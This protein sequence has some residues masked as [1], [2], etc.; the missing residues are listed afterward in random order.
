MKKNIIDLETCIR[1]FKYD[2]EGILY[3]NVSY[4]CVKCGDIAR[5]LKKDKYF[6]VCFDKVQYFTHRILYQLYNN[7]TLKETDEI[8]HIDRDTKNNRKENL[9]IAT[10]SENARNRKMQNNNKLGLKNIQV[11][12]K[13]DY[14]YYFI[15]IQKDKKW[16]KKALSAYKYTIEQVI[17][18]RNNMLKELHGEF[19]CNS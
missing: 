17:E 15:R 19:S 14:K 5:C 11:C 13:N 18:I 1:L 16:Y 6:V 2:F 9:R 3:W 10:R 4:G 7:I 12:Y 8:D